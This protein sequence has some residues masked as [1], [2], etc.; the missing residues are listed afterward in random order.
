MSILY[1]DIFKGKDMG[2]GVSE[3]ISDAMEE[4][5]GDNDELKYRIA[6]ILGKGHYCEYTANHKIKEMKAV[7]FIAPDGTKMSNINSMHEYLEAMGITPDSAHKHV[8]AAHEKASLKAR[9]K[10]FAAPMLDV[11]MWDCYWCIAMILSD[12]WYSVWGDKEKAAMMAYEYLSDPD[13]K[14]W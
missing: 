4:L 10:G 3:H 9:E 2:P 6:I 8:A 13:R 7:A 14:K 5:A 1:R 11:N 12:Y